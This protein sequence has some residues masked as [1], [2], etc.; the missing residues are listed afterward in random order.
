MADL[1]STK[2]NRLTILGYAGSNARGNRLVDVRCDCGTEKVIPLSKVKSVE[3][4][5][6]KPING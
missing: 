1:I 2:F 4:A 6:S 5:L 3:D